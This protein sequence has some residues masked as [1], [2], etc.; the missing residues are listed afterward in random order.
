LAA[1]IPLTMLSE[2]EGCR[3][4]DVLA[5]RCLKRRLAEM[6]FTPSSS[7]KLVGK[8]RGGA[9]LVNVNGV[10]YALGRG[11]AMKIIVEPGPAEGTEIV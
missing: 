3:V 7:I 11:M 6:G 2:G 8:K 1:H 9:L 10:R 5:G 4:K